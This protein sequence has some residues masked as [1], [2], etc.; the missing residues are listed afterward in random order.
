MSATAFDMT[1]KGFC[2][3][4]KDLPCE[5]RKIPG[6]RIWFGVEAYDEEAKQLYCTGLF[7]TRKAA[8]HFIDRLHG[9]A[10]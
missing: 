10:A 6:S 1:R 4:A 2:E 8:E 7:E 5:I 3:R 9:A